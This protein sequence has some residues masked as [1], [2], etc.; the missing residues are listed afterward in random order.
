MSR[1]SGSFKSREGKCMGE[2]QNTLGYG[3]RT[4]FDK[5]LWEYHVTLCLTLIGPAKGKLFPFIICSLPS[6]K[7]GFWYRRWPKC[8][9]SLF[10]GDW[11]SDLSLT[12]LA[13]R[14]MSTNVTLILASW[15]SSTAFSSRLSISNSLQGGNLGS[16]DAY[17]KGFSSLYP[18]AAPR[19]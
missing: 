3:E 11:N 8:A 7:C 4:H 18:A 9:T 15:K 17:I 6:S 19:K 10:E 5:V 2:G 14:G 12:H 16:Y 1:A 13:Q